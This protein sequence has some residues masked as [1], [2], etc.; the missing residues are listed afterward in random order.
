[1]HA[2]HLKINLKTRIVK[3]K[4]KKMENMKLNYLNWYIVRR[5]SY[6]IKYSDSGL[7]IYVKTD[8]A[9]NIRNYV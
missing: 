1:M 3:G 7:F 2:R 9:L 4:K 8:S 5:I 6:E